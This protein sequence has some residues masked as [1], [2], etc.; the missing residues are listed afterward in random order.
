MVLECWFDFASTY[1]YPAVM[2][3]EKLA[4][5]HGVRVAW[6]AFLL[7]PVFSAQGWND[8]PFN[9]YPVKGRYMWRDLERVCD[10]EKIGFRHPSQF[11]RNGLLAA[12]IACWYADA[13]WLPEFIRAVF[14]AN[15]RDDLDIA[16]EAVIV[17]CLT[18]AGQDGAAILAQ[19]QSPES[20]A[21]LRT[22][23]E[24]AFRLGVFGAPFLIAGDDYFLGNERLEQA[25]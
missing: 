18:L 9:L 11:P 23:S 3:I 13:A 2:R 15:F 6:R 17:Q 5:A 24:Q 7:G 20:K 14:I 4:A 8:S 12:R 19:A 16:D 22:Q 25:I 1:S 10:A 21:Q